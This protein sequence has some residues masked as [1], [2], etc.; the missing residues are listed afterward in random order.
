MRTS[1][2]YRDLV[3]KIDQRSTTVAIIGLG[4]VGLP[5]ATMVAGAG[6]K[7]SGIERNPSRVASIN[8]GHSYIEDL[9]N[10][11]LSQFVENGYISAESGFS[12]ISNAGVVSICVPTP[13]DK[14]RNPDTS[15]IEF[16]VKNSVPYMRKG[17]L[18]ILESTTYPGSTKELILPYI[19]NSGFDVGKDFFLC[20]SPERI[21][22]GLSL[23]HI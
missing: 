12:S 7:V 23:I 2:C 22:P 16:V 20:F 14:N 4:Y 3:L 21:D 5:L 10:D 19:Q 15:Y 6:F 17:Q 9:T 13:L 18:L 8:A 11:D 1:E